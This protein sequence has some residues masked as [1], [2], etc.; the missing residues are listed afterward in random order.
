VKK[1]QLAVIGAG[2]WGPNLIR[3]FRVSSRSEVKWICDSDPKRLALL[4]SHY[5]GVRITT[6]IDPILADPSVDAIV[7]CTPTSTHYSLAKRAL[8]SR[9]HVF[10]EKPL[11]TCSPEA[12]ELAELAESL[13]LKLMVGHVFLFNPAVRKLKEIV[14]SDEFGDV[15]YLYTTRTNFGPIRGDVNSFWDLAPHDVSM[16]LYVLGQTPYEV[17]GQGQSF[18]NPPI[19]DVVFARLRFPSGVFANVHVSWLDPRKIRQFVVVGSKMMVVFDDMAKDSLIV[20][21][22]SIAPVD[23]SEINDTREGFRKSILE[24]SNHVIALPEEEPL[25]SECEAFLDLVLDGVANPSDGWFGAEVVKALEG[26]E[27]SL[28]RKSR[29]VRS[30]GVHPRTHG[31]TL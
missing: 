5:K 3:N 19:Q 7:I 16:L 1:L 8:K 10:V 24:G 12:F 28:E 20:V 4:R 27:N 26:V 14:A 31:E 9:K 29:T 15:F 11:A 25:K 22:K 21:D 6:E 18:I 17:T 30:V 23:P 2:H 13:D